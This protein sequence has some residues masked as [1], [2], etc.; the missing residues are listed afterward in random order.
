MGAWEEQ[1]P[2]AQ[3]SVGRDQLRVW[4]GKRPRKSIQELLLKQAVLLSPCT[5]TCSESKPAEIIP[6]PAELATGAS[7]HRCQH[8]SWFICIVKAAPVPL[9]SAGRGFKSLRAFSCSS[10]MWSELPAKPWFIT[11][12][13]HSVAGSSGPEQSPLHR[14]RDEHLH[15]PEW[16]AGA[17]PFPATAGLGNSP[18]PPVPLRTA[19]GV[20]AR[21]SGLP[22]CWDGEQYF[23]GGGT[24]QCL[25]LHPAPVHFTGVHVGWMRDAGTQQWLPSCSEGL[26]PPATLCSPGSPMRQHVVLLVLGTWI[27]SAWVNKLIALHERSRDSS[28]RAWWNS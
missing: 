23:Q 14:C 28:P 5:D 22:P 17:R 26:P 15:L 2:A 16:L 10:W 27:I 9:P 4:A 11:V 21:L 7:K 3:P 13:P 24:G 18:S 20:S 25:S 12:S 1:G 19:L 6:L 8:L